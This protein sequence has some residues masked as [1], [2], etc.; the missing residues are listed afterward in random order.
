MAT[1]TKQI[2][3]PIEQFRRLEEEAKKMGVSLPAYIAFLEQCRLGRL[4]PKAQ[5]AARF[6]FSKHGDSLRKLAQ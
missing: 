4:D 3:L 2:E 6:M 5:D 1:E